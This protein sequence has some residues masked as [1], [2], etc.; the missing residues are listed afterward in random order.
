MRPNTGAKN[1][2]DTAHNNDYDIIIPRATIDGAR[3]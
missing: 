1:V 3:G 2:L